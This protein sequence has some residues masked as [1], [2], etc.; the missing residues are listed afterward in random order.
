MEKRNV[1]D[2]DVKTNNIY[3]KPL[4]QR[5]S[6]L[7]TRKGMTKRKPQG[8]FD[9]TNYVEKLIFGDPDE[10]QEAFDRELYG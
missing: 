7:N 8:Y 2:K 10:E 5:K 9:A 1:K 3:T 4:N 6:K